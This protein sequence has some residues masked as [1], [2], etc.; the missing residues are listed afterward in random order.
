M[1]RIPATLA[2]LALLAPA[3][4]ASKKTPAPKKDGTLPDLLTFPATEK[5]LPNG[6]KVVL[7]PSRPARETRSSPASPDSLTSSST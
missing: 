4:V 5:L 7:V 3:A 6:L 1:L 2:M